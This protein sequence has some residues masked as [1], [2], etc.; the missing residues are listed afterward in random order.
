MLHSVRLRRWFLLVLS[1]WLSQMVTALDTTFVVTV[2]EP[3]QVYSGPGGMFDPVGSLPQ[4][5]AVQVNARNH[6][7]TW[8]H[9]LHTNVMGWVM[10]GHLIFETDHQLVDLPDSQAISGAVSPANEDTRVTRL[11]TYPVLPHFSE[12]IHAVYSLGQA[13]GNQPLAVTKVG[14]SVLENEWY[15]LPMAAPRYN[16]GPYTFLEETLTRYGPAM[17]ASVATRRGLTSSVVFDPL[18][19]D[20]TRCAPNEGPLACEYRLKRPAVAFIMFGPNDMKALS[21][22][23]YQ[24][25]M[26]RVVQA[27]MLQ[28]V[29]PVLITFSSHPATAEWSR[30]LDYNLALLDL[31]DEMEVPLLNLWLATRALPEYGL[32]IDK[33]HLKNSGYDYLAFHRGQEAQSGVALLNLLSLQVLHDFHQEITG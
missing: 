8:V 13:L 5:M 10:T 18:W 6:G 25:S 9:I 3:T 26:T 19:A 4:E 12:R 20:K 1:L 16:L 15:L 32:E 7:G 21:L 33:L 2:R 23:T 27:S 24:E 28:G 31:A 29:V 17:S 22:R 30:S 11:N 14:D